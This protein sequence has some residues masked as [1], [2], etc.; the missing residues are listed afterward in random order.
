MKIVSSIALTVLLALPTF[1]VGN[2]CVTTE[3]QIVELLDQYAQK[4]GT[5]FVIDP[6]VRAKV[7]LVG[8]DTLHLDAPTLVGILN[9]HGMVALTANDIV[10]VMPEVVAGRAGQRYGEPWTG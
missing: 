8:I 6:R 7:T 2:E 3:S 10:Y 9:I 4:N 5:K 1:A